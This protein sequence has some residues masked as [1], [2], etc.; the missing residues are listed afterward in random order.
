MRQMATEVGLEVVGISNGEYETWLP[1]ARG[2]VLLIETHAGRP[3]V[4]GAVLDSYFPGALAGAVSPS[5]PLRIN[6]TTIV[7][8]EFSRQVQSLFVNG[9]ISAAGP[10]D[11][12]LTIVC[13]A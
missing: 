10:T 5:K 11:G 9:A 3:I 6:D 2:H 4:P 13:E 1:Q 8:L 12:R 7:F